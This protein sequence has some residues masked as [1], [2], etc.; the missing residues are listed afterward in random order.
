LG[1]PSTPLRW[2]EDG[3]YLYVATTEIPA[4]ILR[5]DVTANSYLVWKTVAPSDPA[6][7]HQIFTMLLT[8]DAQTAIYS[9]ERKLSEVYVVDGWR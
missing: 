9:Y 5:I 4:R 1:F 3:R 8:G 7:V 2:S 6:G